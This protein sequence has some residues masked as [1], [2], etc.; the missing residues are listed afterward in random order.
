M[1]KIINDDNDDFWTQEKS[2][3]KNY[4]LSVYNKAWSRMRYYFAKHVLKNITKMF[5]KHIDLLDSSIMSYD[6]NMNI[7]F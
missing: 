6:G 2:G 5:G 3:N 4:H 7:F 1:I